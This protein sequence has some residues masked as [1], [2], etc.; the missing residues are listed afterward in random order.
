MPIEIPDPL[1]SIHTDSTILGRDRRTYEYTVEI[2]VGDTTVFTRTYSD[3]EGL[4]W[5]DPKYADGVEDA[6]RR[7]AQAFGVRLRDLLEDT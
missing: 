2:L 5:E 4:D 6:Q 7:T 3:D 1:F